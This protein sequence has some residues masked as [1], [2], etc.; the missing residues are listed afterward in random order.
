ML[1]AWHW[2]AWEKVLSQIEELSAEQ[3][4][5]AAPLL[6]EG[7][8]RATLLHAWDVEETWLCRSQ[9]I[10]PG[11]EPSV[12]DVPT[13][14]DLRDRWRATESGWSSFLTDLSDVDL[15]TEMRYGDSQRQYVNPLWALMTHCV[16]HGMQHRSE[17]AMVITELGHSP[18]NLDFI[19]HVTRLRAGRE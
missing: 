2:W 1:F 18:G 10:E 4:A 11:D 5:A 13:L 7:S 8:L 6:N 17:V 9:G 14:A 3:Y 12:E 19:I 16:T 15:A